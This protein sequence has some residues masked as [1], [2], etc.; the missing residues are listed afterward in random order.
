MSDR[1]T[2]VPVRRGL[3]ILRYVQA[4]SPS[5][6]PRAFVRPANESR[7]Q[8]E[9]ISAPGEQ[10]GA[11]LA[12]GGGVVV[13]AEQPGELRIVV[14]SAG[15]RDVDAEFRLETLTAGQPFSGTSSRASDWNDGARGGRRD[16]HPRLEVVGHVSRRGDVRSADGQWLAGPDAPAPIEGVAFSVADYENL[17][18]EYQVLIGGQN[19]SWTPWTAGNY[20]GTRGKFQSLHGIR[21]RLTGP[22]AAAFVLDVDALFLGS[23]IA[24]RKGSEVELISPAGVDPLVGL[25]VALLA[26]QTPRQATDDGGMRAPGSR[27][28]VGS[29]RVRVF[30]AA[31]TR[32]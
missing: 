25:K 30:R 19:G 27:G 32:S 11:L 21:L 7:G 8:I 17:G 1:E 29:G 16:Q 31:S 14:Q 24:S 20:S 15:G 18:I 2:T 10:P 9:V 23:T 22:E 5:Q 13:R 3:F 6:A 28:E 4:G 12:P 26:R